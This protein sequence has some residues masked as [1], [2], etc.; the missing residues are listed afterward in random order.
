MKKSS[1]ESLEKWRSW[2]VV[3][4]VSLVCCSPHSCSGGPIG[5]WQRPFFCP[6]FFASWLLQLLLLAPLCTQPATSAKQKA[7]EERSQ[8]QGAAHCKEAQP[9]YCGPLQ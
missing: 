8:L 1:A 9:Q 5:F 2:Q 4:V 7:E 3:V 6:A